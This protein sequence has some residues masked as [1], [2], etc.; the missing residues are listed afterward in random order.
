VSSWIEQTR[1]APRFYTVGVP[2]LSAVYFLVLQLL[3]GLHPEHFVLVGIGLVLSLGNDWTRKLARPGLVYLLYGIVYDSMRYYEDLIR[4]PVI[5]VREPYDFDLRWFGINGQTP[6]EW[7]Q[8]HTNAVL[9]FF[10]GLSY[11]PFF[12]IG[13]SILLTIYLSR[14]MAGGRSASSGSSSSPT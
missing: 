12:F 4:S 10:C 9:D 11:T 7:L 5:H 6:N 8:Q 14:A 3:G 1:R 2:V 13:E